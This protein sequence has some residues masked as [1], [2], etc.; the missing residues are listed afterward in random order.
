MSWRDKTYDFD[1]EIIVRKNGELHG[2]QFWIHFDNRRLWLKGCYR[3]GQP[4]GYNYGW[5]MLVIEGR[6]K[7][8]PTKNYCI[9]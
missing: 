4:I 1:D 7:K 3:Y 2:L 8:I 6:A 5:F 9:I